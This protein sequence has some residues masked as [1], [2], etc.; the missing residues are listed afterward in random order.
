MGGYSTFTVHSGT[1]VVRWSTPYQGLH[2]A[3]STL[4][5]PGED[6]SSLL[7]CPWSNPSQY[8]LASS[9]H[10]QTPLSAILLRMRSDVIWQSSETTKTPGSNLSQ[11][12]N[13]NKINNNNNDNSNDNN[14]D[15]NSDK[16]MPLLF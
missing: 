15:A 14:E 5:Q 10:L 12:D 4:H 2:S 1:V 3:T 6:T 16:P 13:N 8:S 9:R 11:R 7:D